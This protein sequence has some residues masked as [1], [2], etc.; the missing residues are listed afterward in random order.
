MS[1]F[2]REDWLDHRSESRHRRYPWLCLVLRQVPELWQTTLE[3]THSLRNRQTTT[4]TSALRPRK[5]EVE[6]SVLS[7]FR[8][9]SRNELPSGLAVQSLNHVCEKSFSTAH[10]SIFTNRIGLWPSGECSVV[11][12]AYPKFLFCQEFP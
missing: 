7:H 9:L 5:W 2:I 8:M 10:V 12:R 4:M 11:K 1:H 6:T 3:Q